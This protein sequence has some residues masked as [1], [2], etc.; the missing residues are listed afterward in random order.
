MSKEYIILVAVWISSFLLLFTIP[1]EMRRVGATAFLFKQVM[2]FVLG[3]LAVENGMLQYPVRELA[4]VNRASFTYEFLAYPV[5]CA[6][7]NARYPRHTSRARQCGYYVL[8][9]SLFTII[10]VLIEEYTDLVEYI[11]WHWFYTYGSLFITFWITKK[12]CDWFFDTLPK[13]RAE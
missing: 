10:E 13:Y 7:F 8:Y 2:T 3:Y 1:K 6:V 4:D 11:T 9:C 5:L 12:F